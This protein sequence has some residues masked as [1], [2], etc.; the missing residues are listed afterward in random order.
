MEKNKKRGIAALA[1]VFL[2]FQVI[3]FAAPFSRNAVFWLAYLFA[4]TAMAAQLYVFRVSMPLEGGKKS[5]F[6][7]FPIAW[8][9]I[10]YLL[11][12][13][14]A[15]FLEMAVSRILPFWIPLV[16]NVILLA[17]AAVGLLA[18][19]AVRDEIMRQ[20]DR[21][22][23]DTE[24]MREL[25]ATAA[26]LDYPDNDSMNKA[27]RSLAEEFRYSDPVSCSQTALQEAVLKQKMEKLKRAVSEKN[28]E[29]VRTL[30]REITGALS[31]RNRACKANK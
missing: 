2:V 14:A 3:S 23:A 10:A 17:A 18:T 12:Q 5:R 6:Y 16:L 8:I 9:G 21:Q 1:I 28:E 22:K 30:C 11:V 24:N 26:S 19:D 13:L 29:A 7:G 15:S 4:L 31:E 20:E 27:L 25:Y